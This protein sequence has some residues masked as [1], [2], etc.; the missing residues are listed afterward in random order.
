MEVVFWRTVKTTTNSFNYFTD[1]TFSK[2]YFIVEGYANEHDLDPASREFTLT[3][4]ETSR[5]NAITLREANKNA[6]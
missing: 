3:G 5:S 2:E 1:G 4:I 6:A